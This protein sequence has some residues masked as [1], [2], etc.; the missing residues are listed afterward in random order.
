MSDFKL[1][2]QENE[3]AKIL[4]ELKELYPDEQ[5]MDLLDTV[6]G[7]TSYFDLIASLEEKRCMYD[8]FIQ[9]IDFRM[10][11]LRARKDRL[12]HNRA[13]LA[14]YIAESM[15]RTGVKKVERPE[16]TISYRKPSKAV[17]ILDE[18]IIPNTFIKEKTTKSV[19]KAGIAAAIKA[20]QEIAGAALVDG[21]PSIT[22]RRS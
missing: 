18:T 12:K 16:F 10:Q 22:V 9:A 7:E 13:I 17:N 20:G 3:F 6:D 1:R 2:E 19:D 11:E 4:A 5:E 21:S 8:D 15:Q 14:L